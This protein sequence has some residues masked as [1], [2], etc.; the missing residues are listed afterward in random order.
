MAPPMPALQ[1]SVAAATTRPKYQPRNRFASAKLE[2]AR[3]TRNPTTI[4]SSRALT[5]CAQ[6]VNQSRFGIAQT[7]ALPPSTH[8]A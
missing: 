6:T 8:T 4:G 7:N 2:L 5:I 1:V 3:T